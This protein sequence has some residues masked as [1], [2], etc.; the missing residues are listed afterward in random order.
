M[1]FIKIVILLL[2][3]SLNAQ[4]YNFNKG[5]ITKKNY[6]T[7]IPYVEIQGKIII[8][9]TIENHT[10]QFL[11]DTGATNLIVSGLSKKIKSKFLKKIRVNDANGKKMY[12]N[13]VS[14]P[15]I[16]L[17]N[18]T[19]KKTP[20]IVNSESAN[21]I[22]DCFKVD[23]IIGSNMLR[24]SI[25]QILPKEK[26]LKISSNTD[27]IDYD[28]K[29]AL[30]LSLKG[31]QSSPYIW[32]N[33]EGKDKVKEHVLFDTG[34]KGFYDL[35]KKN[36][37]ILVEKNIFVMLSRSVGSNSIGLFGASEK[38]EQFRLLT[39]KLKIGDG[40]FENLLTTT[41]SSKH[42]RIGAEILEYG[43]VTLDFRNK[44]F[45]FKQYKDIVDMNKKII[46]MDA[47]IINNKIVVGIV[48]DNELKD[49]IFHGEEI[50]SVNG[51]KY[52]DTDICDIITQ[53][54]ILKKGESFEFELKDE[55][56]K[57]KKITLNKEFPKI[58][59]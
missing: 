11:F 17:G 9:V 56:G 41:T 31:S 45:E 36:Y 4:G 37:R 40:I 57:I 34:M 25:V 3:I 19:F 32:I 10:Y 24:N 51:K 18:I 50:I 5:K 12:L 48:W 28:K 52:D 54:S 30:D 38:N 1:K 2:S 46:G 16:T 8:P 14:V 26:L 53:E 33:L 29:N 47:T 6:Y 59:K 23:G 22:F 15:L 42:S 20:T 44:K 21:F 27:K 43:S 58:K 7:E 35:S 55:E 39:P 49:Q 13:V